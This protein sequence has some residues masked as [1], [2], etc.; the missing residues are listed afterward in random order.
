[1]AVSRQLK[2][3]VKILILGGFMPFSKKEVKHFFSVL[4]IFH[5]FLPN[6]FKQQ[7]IHLCSAY[8]N[9]F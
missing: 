5:I 7:K 1:M 6:L 3:N 8:E 4:M 9:N 2:K